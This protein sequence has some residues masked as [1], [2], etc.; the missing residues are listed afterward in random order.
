[1]GAEIRQ[2]AV[3]LDGFGEGA[4]RS[5]SDGMT[6]KTVVGT[7][8]AGRGTQ[9]ACKRSRRRPAEPIRD[10]GL[11]PRDSPNVRVQSSPSRHDEMRAWQTGASMYVRRTR[12]DDGR[13]GVGVEPIELG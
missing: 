6:G 12:L 5:R 10:C 9:S 13:V 2:V 4:W 8:R 7:S 3:L 1:M 11:R